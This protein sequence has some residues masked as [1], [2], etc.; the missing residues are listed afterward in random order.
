M[1][2]HTLKCSNCQSPNIVFAENE[3]TWTLKIAHWTLQFYG[4]NI[5]NKKESVKIA[6]VCRYCLDRRNLKSNL[7]LA[8]L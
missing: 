2:I 1:S 4:R 6:Y 5:K 3:Q 8:L 7:T